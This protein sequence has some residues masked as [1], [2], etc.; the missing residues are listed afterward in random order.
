VSATDKELEAYIPF[1]AKIVYPVMINLYNDH[2][3]K[4]GVSI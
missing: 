3:K 1:M 2:M 4:G